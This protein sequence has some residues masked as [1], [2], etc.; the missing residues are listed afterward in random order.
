MKL[1]VALEMH[2]INKEIQKVDVKSAWIG[3]S[4][5]TLTL[6]VNKTI[7]HEN[8]IL[9]SKVGHLRAKQ[10]QLFSIITKLQ[11]GA[12]LVTEQAA[13][14]DTRVETLVKES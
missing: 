10:Q 3:A 6:D 5:V 12:L 13:I 14:V 9:V 1:L 2:Q 8:I 4:L 7:M 11:D